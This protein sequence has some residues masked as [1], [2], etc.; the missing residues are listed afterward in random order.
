MHVD[1]DAHVVQPEKPMPPHWAQRAAVHPPG[2]LVVVGVEGAL[3]VVGLAEV[4]DVTS[5]V[6][7]ELLVALVAGLEL[8][9]LE[10]PPP[11]V[12]PVVA[13]RRHCHAK[14]H[15][16]SSNDSPPGPD[17]E[18]VMLPLSMYTPDQ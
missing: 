9:T 18:V 12:E 7:V 10:L 2:A 14:V 5:V 8:E 16:T 15:N 17:T 11:P 4:V 13:V 6:L 3:V 1:P